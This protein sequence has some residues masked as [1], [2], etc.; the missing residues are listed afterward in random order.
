MPSES[1]K[2]STFS[3]LRWFALKSVVGEVIAVTSTVALARLVTPGQF[4]HAAVALLFNML[5]VIL[6]FEGFAAALVQR[7]DI[8]ERHKQVSVLL[9]LVGGAGLMGLVLLTVPIVWRPIFGS[10][11]AELIALASPSFLLAGIGSVA[12]ALLWR[13]LDFRRV[14]QI[15]LLSTFGANV[16]SV[17][18]AVLHFGAVALV[19]G[20][21]F[22]IAFTSVLMLLVAREPLPRFHWKE[23]KDIVGYG[24][25]SAFANIVGTLQGNVDYWIVAARL[26]AYRTGIYYRAFSLGVN[27][28]SKISNVMMQLAFP[29]YSRLETRDE[30]RRLHE[31]GVRIHAA[32]I[33]PLLTLLIVIAPVAIPFVFGPEWRPA[34]VPTQI[35]AG[36]GMVN[37]MLTGY[38]QILQAVG[39][40]Q[41]LLYSNLAILVVYSAA[42][43]AVVDH[44]LIAVAVAVVVVYIGILAWVYQFLLGPALGLSVRS[45]VPELGPALGSCLIMVAVALPLRLLIEGYLPSVITIAVVAPIAAGVY[46]SVLRLL[47]RPAWDDLARILVRT[48]PQIARF[49]GRRTQ[50]VAAEVAG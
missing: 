26:G 17:V 50:A 28:Q 27:Y 8:T 46:V 42:V 34:V 2:Q 38:G 14:T 40:P 21:D 7:P 20:A 33:F 18:M 1:V 35:L 4:G 41:I 32:T 3:G 39:R 36:A 48:V 16:V 43:L 49:R 30:M 37:A 24:A 25:A 6:T 9:N 23:A 31:R 45:L 12:R 11:T 22:G 44:G 47:F 29:V 10:E 19:V 13:R 15:D 5:A